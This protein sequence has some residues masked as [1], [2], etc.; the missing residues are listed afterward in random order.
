MYLLDGIK[1]NFGEEVEITDCKHTGRVRGRIKDTE[2]YVVLFPASLG[3]N[4]LI[5]YNIRFGLPNRHLE[6]AWGKFSGYPN[7]YIIPA[8]MMKRPI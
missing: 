2:C 8:H 6:L 4:T 3:G 7:E 5:N 1:F